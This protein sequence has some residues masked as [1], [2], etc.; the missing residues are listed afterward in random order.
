MTQWSVPWVFFFASYI[1][2][3]GDEKA[4][5]LEIPMVPTIKAPEKAY[6]LLPEDHERSSLPRQ[7]KPFK[8]YLFYS[9]Q[10]PQKKSQ[11]PIS[12]PMPAKGRVGSLD[13]YS[14]QSITRCP[15]TLHWGSIR[16]CQVG[17]R[18]VSVETPWGVGTAIPT[19]HCSQSQF[20]WRLS[21]QPRFLYSS[22]INE[23]VPSHFPCQDNVEQSQLKE[24]V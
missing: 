14:H 20:N 8:Y 21:G 16:E 17:N 13:F 6:C 22:G 15:N 18:P 24:K 9:S 4:R 23:V 7:K 19:Q 2:D 3:L 12:L 10:I 11:L 5:N 1:V